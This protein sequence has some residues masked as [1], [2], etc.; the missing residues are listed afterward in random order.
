MK[1][2]K[3]FLRSKKGMGGEE[4]RGNGREGTEGKGK[5]KGSSVR[6]ILLQGLKGGLDAPVGK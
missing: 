5:E 2:I 1:G 3:W 4:D 6:G